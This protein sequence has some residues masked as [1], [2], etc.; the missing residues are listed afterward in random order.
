M[1]ENRMLDHV[2]LHYQPLGRYSVFFREGGAQNFDMTAD[3]LPDT[4][5]KYIK[6]CESNGWY[7]DLCPNLRPLVNRPDA[8]FAVRVY[9]KAYA[10]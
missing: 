8:L 6:E 4:L 9:S 3:Q 10:K 1:D 5:Q 2:I 7:E